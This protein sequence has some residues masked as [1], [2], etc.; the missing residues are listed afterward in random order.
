MTDSTSDFTQ[1]VEKMIKS[2]LES[3]DT[4]SFTL[5]YETSE[6]IE[7]SFQKG[8]TFEL[9]KSS[10][11]VKEYTELKDQEPYFIN[12]LIRIEQILH[13]QVI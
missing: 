3:E 9:G 11:I 10:L 13:V 2:A 12:Y 4:L 7:I 5:A 8:T 1:A 6:S